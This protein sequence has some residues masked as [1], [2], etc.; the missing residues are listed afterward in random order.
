MESM[1]VFYD[2]LF[3][4]LCD[5]LPITALI[6]L[7]TVALKLAMMF[8]KSG[9]T[10]IIEQPKPDKK[11]E[12]KKEPPKPKDGLEKYFDYEVKE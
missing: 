3:S 8:F 12:K 1:A 6:G 10:A 9:T 4:K 2:A 11:L 5:V 7:A